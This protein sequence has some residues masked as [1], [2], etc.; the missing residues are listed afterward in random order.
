M[1]KKFNQLKQEHGE[2]N[3]GQCK[4][5]SFEQCLMVWGK[6]AKACGTTRGMENGVPIDSMGGSVQEP[7]NF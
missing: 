1:L 4:W 2:S 5:P 3:A 6:T 7:V